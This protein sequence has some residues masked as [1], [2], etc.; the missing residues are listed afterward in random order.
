MGDT[1]EIPHMLHGP[2]GRARIGAADRAVPIA[3]GDEAAGG[4]DAPDLLVRK[5]AVGLADGPHPAMAGNERAAGGGD[6]FGDA[7]VGQVGDI[8]DHAQ[9]LHPGDDLSAE[10]GESALFDAVHGAREFI[11]EEV[12][13]PGHA[14]A[15]GVETFEIFRLSFKVLKAFDRQHRADG[16]GGS[17]GG[18]Q[19]GVE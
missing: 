5:V 4:G 18:S 1:D 14:E 16:P 8:D 12:G 19:Q 10:R 17:G 13:K 15:G 9:F 2:G 7:L 11:V 3:D 6:E